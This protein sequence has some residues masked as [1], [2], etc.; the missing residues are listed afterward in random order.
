MKFWCHF[1][2]SQDGLSTILTLVEPRTASIEVSLG[3]R[4]ISLS[5][6]RN[7]IYF[8]IVPSFLRKHCFGSSN[9]V[10]EK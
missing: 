3:S 7:F 4:K 9:L 10:D 8:R 2:V 6:L 5:N 1:I